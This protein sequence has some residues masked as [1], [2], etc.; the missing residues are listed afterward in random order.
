M[1]LRLELKELN[2]QEYSMVMELVLM[3]PMVMDLKQLIMN[4]LVSSI[5]LE[6]FI[7]VQVLVLQ[8]NQLAYQLFIIKL[9]Q[10]LLVINR[11]Q[12]VDKYFHFYVL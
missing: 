8:V 10:M 6:H 11:W 3:E 7:L 2:Q 4:P 1:D 5:I 12:L 9:E